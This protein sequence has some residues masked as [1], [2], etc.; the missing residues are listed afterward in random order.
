MFSVF[1]HLP[2]QQLERKPSKMINQ[3]TQFFI[4]KPL[5]FSITN[6]Y[7]II[8]CLLAQITSSQV[9]PK[10][11]ACAPKT[12]PNNNQSISFPFYIQ[13]TQEPYCGSPGFEIS[14][15]LDGFPI[16][17]LSH[18]QYLIHQIFY[19]N[20]SLRLSNAAFS[21]LQSNT[22]RGCLVPT[23]NLTLPPTKVF[24]VAPNQTDMVLFYGCDASTLHDQRVGCSVENETSS[25]L[26]L[27]KRDKNIS[28]MAKSCKGD[29]V[30]TVV[31][32]GTGGV[33]EALRKGFLLS[34]TASNCT[35]CNSTE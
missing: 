29:V 9:D 11:V 2:H 25:V 12:C 28:F 14:C 3:N 6:S 23:Q 31:E 16:L 30:N 24:G 32:D 10:F 18:T 20:Q 34:W 27:D 7:I 1:N 22:T 33:D 35:P 17:N 26:A 19:Q 5:L 13:G 8:F 4:L 21:A 15:S